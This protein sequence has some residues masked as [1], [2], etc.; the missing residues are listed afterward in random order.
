MS[1]KVPYAQ[2]CQTLTRLCPSL[3]AIRLRVCPEN[4][5][6]SFTVN[7]NAGY[8]YRGSSVA[9]CTKQAH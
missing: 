4:W 7:Q 8:F 2:S 1:A 5:T 9:L 6:S 3:T